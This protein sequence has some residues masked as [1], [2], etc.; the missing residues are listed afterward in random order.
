MVTDRSMQIE[1]AAGVRIAPDTLVTLPL[2][3]TGRALVLTLFANNTGT[4]P[5]ELGTLSLATTAKA[6]GGPLLTI[7]LPG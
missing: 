5:L 6:R 3:K 1:D 7:R 2:H 4:G